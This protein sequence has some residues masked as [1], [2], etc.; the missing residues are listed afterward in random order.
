MAGLDLRITAVLTRLNYIILMLLANCL[1]DF[2]IFTA[3]KYRKRG[4]EK[5]I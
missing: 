5:M 3:V 1:T 2:K 4:M